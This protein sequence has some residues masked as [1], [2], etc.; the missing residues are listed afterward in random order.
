MGC[1]S[2]KF[3]TVE[4]LLTDL[5]TDLIDKNPFSSGDSSVHE[6]RN[7]RYAAFRQRINDILELKTECTLI[8]D[9]PAGNSY[10]LRYNLGII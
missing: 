3:T 10:I 8:L 5:R 4:G 2:G 1:I 6:G 7:E 9:D